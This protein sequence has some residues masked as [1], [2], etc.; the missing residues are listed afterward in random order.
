MGEISRHKGYRIASVGYDSRLKY[1]GGAPIAAVSF[2]RWAQECGYD[3]DLITFTGS[4]FPGDDCLSL[5][6]G[7]EYQCHKWADFHTILNGYDLV[8][9]SSPMGIMYKRK[10]QEFYVEKYDKLVVPFYINIHGEYDERYY[11]LDKVS[12]ILG[13]YNCCGLVVVGFGYWDYLAKTV[14]KDV[15]EF[16]PCTLPDYALREHISLE[17]AQMFVPSRYRSGLLYAHRFAS[18]KRPHHLAK[19]TYNERFTDRVGPITALGAA[20]GMMQMWDRDNVWPIKPMWDRRNQYF[21]IFD[22]LRMDQ[23]YGQYKYFWDVSGSSKTKYEMKRLDL[24]GVEAVSRGC[25]PLVN[26]AFCPDEI[27]DISVLVDIERDNIDE[28]C[29]RLGEINDNYA[30]YLD[31][32]RYTVL[33]SSM[34]YD[35]VKAKVNKM[36]RRVL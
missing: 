3:C 21:N 35:A 9:F 14:S 2:K 20:T 4:G 23:L 5:M 30:E 28:V 33:G 18:V 16:Y 24:A 32:L 6:W 7:V 15:F 22:T 11:D 1:F 10:E 8:Y 12:H 27:L 13:M 26:K 29:I 36:I 25:F 17:H 31:L 19:L 34:S